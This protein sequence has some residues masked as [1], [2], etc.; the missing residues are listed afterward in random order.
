MTQAYNLSQLANNL[1]S[2]GKLDATDGL[3]NAVPV[4]NGGTGAANATSAR[5]NLGLGSM[6]V[7]AANAVAITGGS[8]T[9]IT[10]LAIADGGTGASS[11]SAARSNLGLVIGTDIPSPTGSGASGTWP[12]SISG[13]AA[14]VTGISASQ[15]AKAW[16]SFFLSSTSPTINVSYNVSS[17]TWITATQFN[18]NFTTPFVDT[19]YL[20]IGS[21]VWSP[22]NGYNNGSSFREDSKRNTKTTSTC[23]VGYYDTY[24]GQS[25]PGTVNA[26]NAYAVF[27][28]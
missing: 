9:G 8:I 24:G 14:N 27:F 15:V 26:I 5:S 2:S 23:P 3:V 11:A 7:Q 12:I 25:L 17:V 19:E 20:T 10:D 6:A 22:W 21:N 16:V 4:A 13:T 28:R 18:V 1:D